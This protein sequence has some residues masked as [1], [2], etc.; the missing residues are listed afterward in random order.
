MDSVVTEELV[1]FSDV[2]EISHTDV[3]METRPGVGH[4]VDF[5][6]EIFDAEGNVIGTS[7]GLAVVFGN[8]EDGSLWQ[9]VSATDTLPEGTVL[10][11]GTYPME[12]IDKD[13]SIPAVGASGSYLGLVG[14]R[15]FQYVERPNDKTTILRS[16]LVLRRPE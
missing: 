4:S 1:L 2:K 5:S 12:P 6:D 14:F 10:W 13:H 9:Q 3:R 15:R 16:S 8:P 11:T 7:K